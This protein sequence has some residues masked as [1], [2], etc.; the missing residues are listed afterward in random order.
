M[1]RSG[2]GILVATWG[3]M[4]AGDDGFG[5]RV[6]DWLERQGPSGLEVLNLGM[7]VG[8][9][10]GHL[11][12]RLG[13]IVVDALQPDAAWPPGQLVDILYESGQ[14]APW[15]HD[16]AVSSHG[17]T[18]G[19]ELELARRLDLLPPHVRLLATVACQ[20]KV[21]DPMSAVVERVVPHAARRAVELA[22]SFADCRERVEGA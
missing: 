9:L 14:A 7:Q 8:G 3:N 20:T 6:A 16:A 18:I 21:G 4:M 5:P 12:G 1:N 13:L 10:L 2:S 11:G 22:A 19:S 15:M 17:L